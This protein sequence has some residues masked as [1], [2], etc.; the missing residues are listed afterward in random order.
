[1]LVD[2]TTYDFDSIPGVL[3]TPAN[4][5]T[6]AWYDASDVSTIS[7]TASAVS[8][9]DDKSG[10]SNHVT[11]GTGT[12]QPETN[13]RTVNSL[14]VIDFDGTDDFLSKTSFASLPA[15]GTVSF[16][17]I[18]IVDAMIAS[19]AE[20]IFSIDHATSDFQFASNST[21][22]FRAVIQNT[23]LGF[24]GNITPSPDV[25][26]EAAVH[27]FNFKLDATA[28][29]GETFV[30]GT[31]K[32]SASGYTTALPNTSQ[33]YQIFTNRNTT[34]PA[35]GACCENIVLADITTGT[36]Q[37]IEGYLAWKWGVEANLPSG[38]PYE[39]AAPTV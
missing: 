3:W 7:E 19:S 23:G 22:E 30:D 25:N 4:T 2:R 14:N 18:C 11:Q 39:F 29:T 13:T 20:S 15:D 9:W 35:Q 38:H 28:Q 31:S 17:S 37:K 16:F 12:K 1:M 24:S 33:A 34:I 32:A 5:T 6:I 8:Q 27:I 26:Y 10:N 36:R 21:T